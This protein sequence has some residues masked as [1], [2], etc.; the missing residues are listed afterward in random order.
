MGKIMNSEALETAVS[1][2]ASTIHFLSAGNDLTNIEYSYNPHTYEELCKKYKYI[3]WSA[4]FEGWGAS[5]SV[6]TKAR[7]IV[8][9]TR[10]LTALNRML[11]SF[12]L[13]TWRTWMRSMTIL[14]F[15]EYLP[16][17]YDDLHFELYGRALKGITEKIPQKYLTL[18][19]LQT[20]APSDLGRIFVSQ[21]VAD[22]TKA[23]AT[24]LIDELK[25]ATI[26]RLRK[27]SWMEADTKQVAVKKVQRM[28]FQVGFP[29][30]WE[31]ETASVAIDA[32]R[33][34][35]N[36]L[37]LAADDSRRMIEDLR[38]NRCEKRIDIWDDGVFEVNAYYYPEGNMMVVPAGILRAPFFDLGRSRAWNLGGIGAA[39]GHEITHGFDADGRLYDEYGNY[40]DWWTPSDTRTY[41]AMTKS[42]IALFH[43]QTY[44]GGKVDGELTLSE[45]LADLGGL[46]IALEA[47]EAKLPADPEKRKVEYRDFFTSFAVSWRQK[48]R[49]KKARQSL[50]L[51]NHAP[52]PLRVNLIVRQFE[53]FYT[54]FDILPTDP[55][56]VP[57]ELRVRLW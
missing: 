26:A 1:I 38:Y 42:L 14:S 55:Y 21:A 25:D 39:I 32:E 24:R 9:N 6:Y 35:L 19:V 15:M 11:R 43:G 46:A 34:L 3:V 16:P 33:P 31:S 12:H 49:P 18:K 20:F 50:L 5:E 13:E 28:K 56:Y 53:A 51:D 7:Y 40:A 29:E 23:Y 30:K 41:K 10:Y 52:A 54:A 22:G 45:N 36:L 47:L 44:M 4:L 37:T 2:E 17:P 57:P 8:T 27:L 48:D